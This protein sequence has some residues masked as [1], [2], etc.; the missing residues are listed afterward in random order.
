MDE[1]H[2]WLSIAVIALVTA[3]VRFF[4]FVVFRN[5]KQTPFLVEK[6]GKV[7][8]YAIMGMLV[9]Y[10]LKDI[11]VT[12]VASCLPQLIASFIVCVLYVWRRNTWLSM[13]AGTVT[14]MLLIQY[15]FV[16]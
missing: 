10:C 5:N 7:L 9:V 14:Y 12:S 2:M 13:I 8:P 4:P 11:R 15:V 1:A 16:S 6:L 3:T